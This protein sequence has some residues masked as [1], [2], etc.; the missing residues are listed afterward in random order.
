MQAYNIPRRKLTIMTK[1]YRITCDS[2]NYDVAA[3]IA[4]HEDL[5][6]QSKNYVN[7][8]GMSVLGSPPLGFIFET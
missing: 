4:M 3:R 1:C 5:A 7:Q 8:W 6:D 2:D